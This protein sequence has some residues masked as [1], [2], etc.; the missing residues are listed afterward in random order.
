MSADFNPQRRQVLRDGAGALASIGVLGLSAPALASGSPAPTYA[1]WKDT[2]KLIVHSANAVET[3]R[4]VIGAHLITPRDQLFIRNNLPPPATFTAVSADSWA[5]AIGGVKQPRSFTLGDLKNLGYVTVA[6]VLQCSGNGR[7]LF[8]HTSAGT[9]WTT[10]AAGCVLWSGLPVK[11]LVDLLGG[12][13]QEVQFMT[14]TG[15]EELPVGLEPKSLVVERSVP[16]RALD[17]AIL[18]W[19]MNGEPLPLAHGGPLRL[20]VPGYYGVN[21]I[22]YVKQVMFTPFQTQARIQA[23]AYRLRP[24]GQEGSQDQQSMWEMNL[25]SW[26]TQPL[27]QAKAGRVHIQGV[28]FGGDTAVDAVEISLDGGQHWQGATFIGPNL[29]PYA[30]RPFV[31]NTE[32]KQGVYDLVCRAVGVSGE[33][34]PESGIENEHGYGHNGWRAHGVKITV[35]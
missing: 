28:A 11:T 35:V 18:A 2:E 33:I 24:I 15:G 6:S 25:K 14:S 10:G 16:I 1:N 27:E 13:A 4:S 31:L 34:Q 26:I 19:E 21:S 12:L 9:Q 5:V 3:Q 20:V 30:W 7:G 29:G 23:E 22:K 8:S 32:L 17:R